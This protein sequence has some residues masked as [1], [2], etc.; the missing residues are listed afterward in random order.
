MA[1]YQV[2]SDNLA[3]PKEHVAVLWKP[4]QRTMTATRRTSGSDGS[5]NVEDIAPKCERTV[6]ESDESS[7]LRYDCEETPPHLAARIRKR[8]TKP[9]TNIERTDTPL[10]RHLQSIDALHTHEPDSSLHLVDKIKQEDLQLRVD[11]R[12]AR[13][14]LSSPCRASASVVNWSS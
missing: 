9:R 13:N 2:A 5:Q 11:V 10:Q 8:L 3:H 12:T 7:E 4:D 1:S 6:T 14:Q